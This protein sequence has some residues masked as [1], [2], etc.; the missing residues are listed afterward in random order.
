MEFWNH[1]KMLKKSKSRSRAVE[2]A[3]VSEIVCSYYILNT[4]IGTTK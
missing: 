3:L 4:I 2:L 1:L